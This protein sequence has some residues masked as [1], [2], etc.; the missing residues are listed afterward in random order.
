MRVKDMTDNELRAWFA[1]QIELLRA[2]G[3]HCSSSVIATLLRVLA[4]E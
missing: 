4:K 3:G 2:K 1:K